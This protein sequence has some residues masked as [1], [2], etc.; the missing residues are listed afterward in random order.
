MKPKEINTDNIIWDRD[1]T[2]ELVRKAFRILRKQGL[3]CHFRYDYD[4]FDTHGADVYI[5]ARRWKSFRKCESIHDNVVH[6]NFEM[7]NDT[8][9]KIVSV[10]MDLGIHIKWNGSEGR[11]IEIIG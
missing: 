11:C 1:K 8:S 6:V 2:C 10:F 7:D 5:D 9:A 3:E 4:K